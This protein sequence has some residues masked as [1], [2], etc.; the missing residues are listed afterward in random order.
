[1][2]DGVSDEGQAAAGVLHRALL[3]AQEVGQGADEE[4]EEEYAEQAGNEAAKIALVRY[5]PEQSGI[6]ESRPES[7][8]R[9]RKHALASGSHP[10]HNRPPRF[11]NVVPNV[12]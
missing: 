4:N 10:R 6:P 7:L 5:Q 9:A 12:A 2:G 11:S 3:A 1:G 8:C